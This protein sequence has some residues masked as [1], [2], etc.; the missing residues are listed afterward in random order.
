MTDSV[1]RRAAANNNELVEHFTRH[2]QRRLTEARKF[3]F[4]FTAPLHH[5]IILQVM[6]SREALQQQAGRVAGK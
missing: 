1:L 6:R 3:A 5:L 4:L 2:F